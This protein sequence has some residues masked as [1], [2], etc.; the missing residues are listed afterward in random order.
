MLFH[1]VFNLGQ[2]REFVE[3]LPH[4][5]VIADV[6]C[7]NGKY[8]GVRPDAVV[9]ASDRSAGLANVAAAR[10]LDRPCRVVDVAIAD[11]LHL[12]FRR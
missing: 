2:V 10:A 6:G 7:G 4:D 1:L 12:P 5:A 8:F 9:L 3:A 11:A